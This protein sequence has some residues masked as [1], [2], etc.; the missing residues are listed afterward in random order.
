[1][2]NIFLDTN[3]WIRPLVEKTPQAQTISKLFQAIDEGV[4]MPYSS[5]VVF[6]EVV[7]VLRSVYQVPPTTI[8]SLINDLLATKNL[9]LIETTHLLKSLQLQQKIK[10]KLTDCLIATQLPK[11]CTLISYDQDFAKI[12]NLTLASPEVLLSQSIG[13]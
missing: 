10:I 11:N 7:Y 9:T 13:T 1:M 6:M 8:T 3:V 4:F 2:T 12:P 5:T